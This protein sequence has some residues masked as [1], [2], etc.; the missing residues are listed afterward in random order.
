MKLAAQRNFTIELF[1]AG[2]DNMLLVGTML[3]DEHLIKLEINV[4]L[5]DEQITRA[6]LEMIR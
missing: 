1:D 5:P 3:D 4:Y 2:D 6:E